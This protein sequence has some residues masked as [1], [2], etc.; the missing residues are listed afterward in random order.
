M[1][2][3]IFLAMLPLVM[4]SCSSDDLGDGGK[5]TYKAIQ[6]NGAE[7]QVSTTVNDFSVRYAFEAF[8]LNSGNTLVAPFSMQISLSMLANGASGNTLSEI[9]NVLGFNNKRLHAR[10]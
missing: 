1:K 7:T 3:L 5:M 4:A 10:A 6:L 8:N 9:L 2:K